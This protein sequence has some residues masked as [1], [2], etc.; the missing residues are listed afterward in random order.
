MWTSALGGPDPELGWGRGEGTQLQE[1]ENPCPLEAMAMETTALLRDGYGT[2]GLMI[3]ESWKGCYGELPRL[4]T[5]QNAGQGSKQG[6]ESSLASTLQIPYLVVHY[7]QWG[8]STVV[9]LYSG[10]GGLREYLPHPPSSIM[11]PQEG[12]AYVCTVSFWVTS[13][14][15]A[16]RLC[17]DGVAE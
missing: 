12:R 4:F 3:L 17:S 2:P 16:H 14:C 11:E 6:I 13:P 10:H 8:K 5:A 9:Y 15:M 7:A 1:R